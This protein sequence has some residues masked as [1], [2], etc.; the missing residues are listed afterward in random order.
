M[1]V[2]IPTYVS[3]S[4]NVSK[5]LPNYYTELYHSAQSTKKAR[6]A[7]NYVFSKVIDSKL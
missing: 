4:P 1:T 6:E 7:M 3:R 5:H 2:T